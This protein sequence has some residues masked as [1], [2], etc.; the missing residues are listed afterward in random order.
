MKK[1][2]L[3]LSLSVLFMITKSFAQTPPV[4]FWENN[5]DTSWHDNTSS[6][7]TLSSAAELAGLSVLVANGDDFS[8]KTIEI[9]SDINLEDHL[10]KPIGLNISFPFSGTVEANHFE[11]SNLFIVTPGGD[12]AGLFGRCV[13]ATLNNINLKNTY[14]RSGDTSGSLVGSF[15]T[16]SNMKNCR[17]EGVDIDCSDYNVGGLVG[18]M[19][20]NSNMTRCSS[21]GIV[22]GFSQV[23][24]LLGSPYNLTTISEC[25]SEGTVEAQFLAGGLVGYSTFAFQANRDNTLINCYS[26]ANASV[27]DGR[28]GG[29]V[30]GTDGAMVVKNCYATGTATGPEFYG[31]LIG[32]VGSVS[33]ENNYWDNESSGLSIA[34]G[35]FTGSSSSF[36]ITGK[37]TAEMKTTA[38]VDLLNENQSYL[39]WS[40]DASKNDGYP[41]LD[42]AKLASSIFVNEINI[43][44]SVFPTLCNEF[45]NVHSTEKIVDYNIVDITGKLIQYAV[46][47]RAETK[48]DLLTVDKGIYFLVLNTEKGKF[49]KKFVKE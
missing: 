21:K 2:I 19:L 30:G 1:N 29:L 14:I 27:I 7:F 6:T 12:F 23:G 42:T 11:I 28:A 44:I 17:A 38:M 9:D 25:F 18:E 20:D 26:R 8:G 49:T 33:T 48:I 5:A 32:A 16:N 35:G 40:L 47:N 4:T 41:I 46:F 37:A 24:G 36:D 34:I 43:E 31:G 10:W 22:K 13:G 45:I 15:A 39:P 3:L